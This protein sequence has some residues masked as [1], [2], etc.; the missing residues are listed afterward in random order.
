MEGSGHAGGGVVQAQLRTLAV[1]GGD[2]IGVVEDGL[3]QLV[4]IVFTGGGGTIQRL[5]L[6][7]SAIKNVPFETFASYR[8]QEEQAPAKGHA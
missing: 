8:T 1:F 4:Y 6:A 3:G 2:G 5:E 7:T